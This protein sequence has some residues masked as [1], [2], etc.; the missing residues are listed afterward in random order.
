MQRAPSIARTFALVCALGLT[1]VPIANA[2]QAEDARR[3]QVVAH[4]GTATITVGELEDRMRQVP[5]YQL[6]TFGDTPEKRT[7][8]FLD[9]VMVPDLLS[10][11]GAQSKHLDTELATSYSL[12]HARSDAAIRAIR[13]NLPPA[14]Q[15]SADQVKKYYDENKARY[16][17]PE[18]YNLWRIL[19]ST[20][21]EAEQVLALAKKDLTLANWNV[22]ARDHSIDKANLMRGGNL[23]FLTIDGI[24]NEVSTTI[25][26]NVVQAA[27]KVKD[28]ELVPEVVPEGTN[29][30]VVWRRGTVGASHRSLSEVEG[31]IR[32]TLWKQQGDSEVKRV[33]DQLR[34]SQVKDFNPGL[35]DTID[36]TVNEGQIV[37]R[38]RPGQVPVAPAGSATP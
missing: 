30:A 35:L 34:A 32:D 22:L 1:L 23:G 14:A 15:I 38:K 18:R 26:P 9:D 36:V 33:T 25:E 5:P 16:D 12:D 11:L 37:P 28:G 31:Q 27:V 20:R 6:A 7:R 10:S 17:A 24:S 3:A 21:Q 4:V 13:K 8:K 29:F 19:T 2:Q